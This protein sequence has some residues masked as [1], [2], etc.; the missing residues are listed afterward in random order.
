[1]PARPN[2]SMTAH[3]LEDE[4]FRRMNDDMTPSQRRGTVDDIAQAIV[5]LASP[6]AAWINGQVLVVD[7]GWSSTKFLSEEA[8]LAQRMPVAATWTHSGRPPTV[9]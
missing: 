1:M 2:P 8:L 3:R 4:R 9:G 5:F 7:G 6:A